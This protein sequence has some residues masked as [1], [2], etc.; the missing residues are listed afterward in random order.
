MI[1]NL[2]L[3]VIAS[4]IALGFVCEAQDLTSV[5]IVDQSSADC[6]VR[7]SGQMDLTES[8][9]AGAPQASF[10]YKLVATNL[11]A[12]TLMAMVV[13]SHVG[14]SNGPLLSQHNEF[15]AYFSHQMEIASG[16]EF[17]DEHRE[18]NLSFSMQGREN[19]AKTSPAAHTEV[20]FLQF[21]DGSTWGDGQDDQVISVMKTRAVLHESLRG[22]VTAVTEGGE[23]EFLKALEAK[24]DDEHADWALSKIRRHQKQN[25]TA[26]AISTVR[27]WLAVADAR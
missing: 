8:K 10:A 7:L 20:I 16:Q 13:L 14:T 3:T 4:M 6:P 9:V 17:I 21:T 15:D 27:D 19:T 1:K 24:S 22:L 25:G 12:K 5:D 2:V 26:A 18:H 23:S 11:S